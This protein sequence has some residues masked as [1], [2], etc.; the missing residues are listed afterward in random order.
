MEAWQRAYHKYKMANNWDNRVRFIVR[1]IYDVDNN[2]F[3]DKN[4]FESMAFRSTVLE[5]KGTLEATRQKTNTKLYMDLW[6]K[7]AELCDFDRNGEVTVDEFKEGMKQICANKTIIQLPKEFRDF[8]AAS[9]AQ[10]DING[11]GL[12]GIEEFRVDCV[13]RLAF[14]DSNAI[15]ASFEALLSEED[16][17]KGGIDLKTY[18]ELYAAFIGSQDA[19]NRAV[20]LFGPLPE[21]S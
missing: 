11:D 19:T 10:I 17:K 4:D 13:N 6:D 5:G 3:L 8:I 20:H 16:R 1:Y 21:L 2:G 15:D 12:I 9:F 14:K 18:Q 7:I